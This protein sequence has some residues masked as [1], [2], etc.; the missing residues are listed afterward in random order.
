MN[1]EIFAVWLRAQHHRV[2]RT[3]SAYWVECGP[4][5]FQAFPY[6]R[7]ITPDESEIERMFLEQHAFALR[8]F[9]PMAS[10]EG[11]PG[12]HVVF[13]GREYLL[14]ALS[15]KA[16]RDVRKGLTAADIEPVSFS[17]MADEG[18][19]LRRQTLQ[20]QG[21]SRSES[22]SG[23]MKL[24][25][26]AGE[27][28]G[29]EAWAAIVDGRLAASLIA[30]TCDDCCSILYQQSLTEF[31][32]FGVNH[33]LVYRFANQVIERPGYPWIFYGCQ[34][35]DAAPGVD[36]FKFRMGFSA[37]PARQRV[38]FHPVFEPW[39]DRAGPYLLQHLHTWLPGNNALAKAAGMLRVYLE[40]SR[41]PTNSR[42]LSNS[43]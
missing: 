41:P 36:A 4:R 32:R 42:L 15:K 43:W 27:L 3:A 24:C 11:A 40:G 13:V 14:R 19:E 22:R 23:W 16:R 29:F 5:V 38:V 30:F 37:R 35:L 21:R 9:N 20:R 12:Y 31:L 6:H 34:S 8:Y 18:W 2:V 25:Q 1:A 28:P 17:R 26:S 33:A 10:K 7:L 39:I